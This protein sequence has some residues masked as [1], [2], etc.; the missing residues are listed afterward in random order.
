MI[1]TILKIAAISLEI[2]GRVHR[3]LK[4]RQRQERNDDATKNPADS[5]SNHFNGV[6]GLPDNPNKAGTPEAGKPSQEH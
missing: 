6:P 4:A 2:A 1:N 5:I 3:A